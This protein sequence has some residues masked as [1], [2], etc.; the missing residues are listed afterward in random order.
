[1]R[2]KNKNM[3]LRGVWT[4]KKSKIR[5]KKSAINIFL[6]EASQNL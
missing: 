5:A 1:M 3:G 2:K 4:I 6:G